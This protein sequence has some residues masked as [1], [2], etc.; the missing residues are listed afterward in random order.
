MELAYHYFAIEF[1]SQFKVGKVRLRGVDVL[2]EPLWHRH[3]PAGTRM[4]V[5]C[6]VHVGVH[7]TRNQKLTATEAQR[8]M[9]QEQ[10]REY[11]FI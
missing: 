1:F 11:L 10:S 6:R 2:L 7:K 8:N 4:Y 5:L 3:I 9:E